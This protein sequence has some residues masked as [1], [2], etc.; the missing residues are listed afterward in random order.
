MIQKQ[1]THTLFYVERISIYKSD[2]KVNAAS[3]YTQ[4]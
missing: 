2:R 4:Q 3:T 1:N